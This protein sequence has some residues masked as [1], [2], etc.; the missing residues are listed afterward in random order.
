MDRLSNRY[1][2]GGLFSGPPPPIATERRE[3]EALRLARELESEY[4]QIAKAC[5]IASSLDA[6]MSVP[7]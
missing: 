1:R 7:G 3:I 4:A 5:P 6:P 2:H